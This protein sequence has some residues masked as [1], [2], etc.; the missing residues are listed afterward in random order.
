[1]KYISKEN[2]SDIF[3]SFKR[4][5]VKAI[6]IG[7]IAAILLSLLLRFAWDPLINSIIPSG[8]IDLSDFANIRNSPVNYAIILLLALLVGGFY[9]EIIFHG[10]IFTRLEKIFKGK[11]ATITAFMLTTITFGLYHFQ[12]GVKGILL[13]AIA[14]A[15][16][17]VLILKFNR[18]L[19][20]GVFV[21][22]FFDFI[23]LTLIY[24]GKLS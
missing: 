7:I 13:T 9:E 19:W 15:V 12:Q 4:F 22:A 21:H 8:K 18:N 10:F 20:Y 14:G 16:Y 23:G 11:W 1:M 3:F 24:L 6:W 2:F 17:H 5:Q